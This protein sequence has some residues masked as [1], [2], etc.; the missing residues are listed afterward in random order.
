MSAFTGLKIAFP[1]CGAFIISFP[2]VII[3]DEAAYFPLRNQFF[4]NFAHTYLISMA[5]LLAIFSF[6]SK[7]AF[8]I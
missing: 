5:V 4:L 6:H 3:C 7:A 2:E 1:S 8:E